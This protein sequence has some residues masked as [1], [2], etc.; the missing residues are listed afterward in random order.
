MRSRGLARALA[1]A[2][3]VMA[4][5]STA[6]EAQVFNY[7]TTGYFSSPFVGCGNTTP[8]PGLTTSPPGVTPATCT[9]GGFTL[10]YTG[11]PLGAPNY[12]APTQINLG[13]F[14]LSGTGSAT[15]P[16]NTVYFTLIINQTLPTVGSGSTFGAITGTVN[17]GATASSSL[18]WSPTEIINISPVMYDLIFDDVGGIR[19]PA[20][21]PKTVTAIATVSTVPEPSTYALL[22]SGLLGLAGLARRRRTTV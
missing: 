16:A 6:V 10:T 7:T 2:T 17:V 8:V 22:G 21:G 15:V 9:G 13:T 14:N 18:V 19:I 12:L 20:Q 1:I 5:S 3:G 4:M 11:Q